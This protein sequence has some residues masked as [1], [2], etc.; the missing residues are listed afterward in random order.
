VVLAPRDAHL[1]KV[2]SNLQEV[3]ARGGPVIVIHTEGDE[4]TA[5]MGQIAIAVPD[6]PERILPMVCA[7]PMQLIAYHMADFKG[8]DV[9]QPRNL[10]KSVTV[11]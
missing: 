5:A 4:E 2:R 10:A 11:E 8:T 7:L 6:V 1:D 3:K 9:D